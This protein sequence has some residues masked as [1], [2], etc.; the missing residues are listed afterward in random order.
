MKIVTILY[1]I[2]VMIMLSQPILL[3]IY[4]HIAWTYP[5]YLAKNCIDP[6]SVTYVSMATKKPHYKL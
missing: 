1:V 5:M 3:K 6:E 4:I 2:V